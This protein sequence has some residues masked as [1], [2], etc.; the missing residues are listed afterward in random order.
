VDYKDEYSNWAHVYD[1]FGA[2][3]DIDKK[4][5]AAIYSSAMLK[6]CLMMNINIF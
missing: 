6:V 5:E 4:E 3:T 1:K 2:I